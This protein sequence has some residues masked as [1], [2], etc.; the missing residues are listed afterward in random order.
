[1][2]F[3]YFLTYSFCVHGMC[4]LSCQG[5]HVKVKRQYESSPTFYR[6]RPR[7]QIQFIKLGR[8]AY[9]CQAVWPLKR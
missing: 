7:E 2:H 8:S 4:V 1:M 6:V 5:T 9:T 3:I